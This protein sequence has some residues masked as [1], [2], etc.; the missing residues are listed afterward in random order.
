MKN[1]KLME[2]IKSA[3]DANFY[4]TAQI[5][6]VSAAL[7]AIVR[8]VN[9]GCPDTLEGCRNEWNEVGSLP[10]VL[11]PYMKNLYELSLELGGMI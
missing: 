9:D 2:G 5:D 11:L 10:T 4:V 1:D 8:L 6:V 3:T 7:S